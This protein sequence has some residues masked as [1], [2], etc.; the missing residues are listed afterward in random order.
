MYTHHGTSIAQCSTNAPLSISAHIVPYSVVVQKS[1]NASHRTD[2]HILIPQLP[3]RPRHN[4]LLADASDDA[5]Y[6]LW[7][8]AAAG[9]DDLA[10]YIFGDGGGT[11]EGEEDGGL[12]LG[13]GALGF[14]FGD[15]VGEAGPFAEG[16]VD[17]VVDLGF[18]FC[19]EVDAP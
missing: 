6:L 15:V 13:F 12:E 1:L 4:V 16:E 18:I 5:L 7:V 3:P 14:G 19:D 17:E 10:A 2:R 8:H 9:G 11:V